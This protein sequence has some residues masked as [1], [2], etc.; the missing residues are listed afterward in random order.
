MAAD[1]K[2]LGQ[3]DLVGIPPAPRGVPQVEVTFDID[4]NGIVNVSAKDKA[5]G[6]E[7]QI[8][9]QASGGL[10]DADIERM[11]KEA[12][13]NAEEDKKRRHLVDLKNQADGL[14]H[15]AEKNLK[16]HGDKISAGDKSTI[17]KDVQSLK[18]ALASENAEQ[19]EKQ[20]EVL[21]Q[22]TMKLGEA[23]YKA[24]Q[25]GAAAAGGTASSGSE[26]AASGSNDNVVDATYEEVDESK[27]AN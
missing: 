1:N 12:Q 24:Q 26:G 15:S 17:E 7:Q 2:L 9:I 8:R 22:S 10:S 23:L 16:E 4:S 11:V 20:V 6:K 14:I 27:K 13:A 3:F 25:E 5:T 18:D 19:I 21:T